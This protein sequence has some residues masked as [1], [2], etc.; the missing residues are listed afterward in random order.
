MINYGCLMGP[1]IALGSPVLPVSLPLYLGFAGWTVVYDTLYAHQDREDDERIGLG[2]TAVA[3]GREGTRIRLLGGAGA[4][5]AGL[6]GAGLGAGME[7]TGM[8]IWAMGTA[9]ATGWTAGI[10]AKADLDDGG[11]IGEAFEE[12]GKIG[13]VVVAASAAA[14]GATMAGI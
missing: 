13:A 10:V 9:V 3:Y 4:F 14:A 7:G 5:G 2:S 1:T 6:M 11:K 8:A 12:F